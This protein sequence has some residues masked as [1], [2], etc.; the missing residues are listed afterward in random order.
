MRSR[1]SLRLYANQKPS[2]RDGNTLEFPGKVDGQDDGQR[3]QA[4]HG[5][6]QDDVALERQVGDGVDATLAAD[7]FV[8]GS[9]TGR[10]GA[11]ILGGLRA[12]EGTSP[13]VPRKDGDG[14]GRG[15][16]LMRL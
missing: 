4:D 9:A 16:L 5:H 8:P 6:E 3:Q 12:E 2:G 1:I 11:N 7:L 14:G 13:T 10:E 15:G